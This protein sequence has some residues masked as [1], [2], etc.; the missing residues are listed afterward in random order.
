MFEKLVLTFMTLLFV[1]CTSD[2]SPKPP[3]CSTTIC[4]QN[5]VTLFVTIS[6]ASGVAIPLDSYKV[7]DTQTGEDITLTT[8]AEE[9][10]TFRDQGTY[11]ILN[12]AYRMQYQNTNTTISF[13]GFI[14]GE[15]VVSERFVVGA[16]CCH[17][18]LISG[19]TAIIID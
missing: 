3:D 13:T 2:D 16:D 12:D 15:E 9:F 5:F 17:V 10:E 7:V 19:N 6:D 8:G 14:S 4:T 11:P 18:Q 1:G